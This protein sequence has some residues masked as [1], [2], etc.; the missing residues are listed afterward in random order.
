M[1]QGRR[2]NPTALKKLAGN[3]GRRPLSSAE[4][5]PP[6]LAEATPPEWLDER[7]REMW[8]ALSPLLINLKVLTVADAAALSA[9]C[10]AWSEWRLARDVVKRDGMVSEEPVMTRSGEIAGYKIRQ[11]PE[12]GI[13][14]DAWR[15]VRLMMVEF[16]LTPASRTKV[17]GVTPEAE[18][19]P[20]DAF[21]K[22]VS[23]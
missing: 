7:A 5:E 6:V 1:A 18:A 3:P 21:E 10:D 2:P 23:R 16:G 14:S 15:R 20:F 17:H 13:A 4:P 22:Q 9:L 11:R 19:D 12:V 8:T